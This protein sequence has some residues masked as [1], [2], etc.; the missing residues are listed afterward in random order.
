MRGP[1]DSAGRLLLLGGV[2]DRNPSL[3]PRLALALLRSFAD[4]ELPL[5]GG[6]NERNPSLFPRFA[7]LFA[8]PFVG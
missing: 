1:F 7:L 6:V 2:N 5:F 8:G 4:G 3:L